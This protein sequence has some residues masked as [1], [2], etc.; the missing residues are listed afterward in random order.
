MY[1][2]VCVCVKGRPTDIVH[3]VQSGVEVNIYR[4]HI[5]P[6]YDLKSKRQICRIALHLRGRFGRLKGFS[7]K[8]HIGGWVGD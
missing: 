7:R 6:L 1:V 4:P 5:F 2:C 3:H 8:F